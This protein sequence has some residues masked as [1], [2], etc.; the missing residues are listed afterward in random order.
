MKKLLIILLAFISLSAYGQRKQTIR[1]LVVKDSLTIEA[2][3][4]AA[5][6]IAVS[7]DGMGRF[8]WAYFSD[9]QDS[10]NTAIYDTVN[11]N[12]VITQATR[13]TGAALANDT[14]ASIGTDGT[15]TKCAIPCDSL[16]AMQDSLNNTQWVDNGAG[17]T[18]LR[19]IGDNVGIGTDAPIAKLHVDGSFILDTSTIKLSSKT[20][21][22]GFVNG[23]IFNNTNSSTRIGSFDGGL[24]T[25]FRIITTINDDST[26]IEITPT[27]YRFAVTGGG[28][29]GY[30]TGTNGWYISGSF[31]YQDGSQADGYILTS[32]ASGNATWEPKLNNLTNANSGLPSYATVAAA[33]SDGLVSGDAFIL[34]GVTLGASVVDVPCFVP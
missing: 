14:L 27:S 25:D 11:A 13:I 19:T 9:F 6:K 18:V 28:S 15:V 1:E 5:N 23:L 30:N 10:I 7:V 22:G 24:A 2:G 4:P 21:G 32:D 20:I 26:T 16:L 33:I 12:V 3:S 29:F 34:T 8:R 31:N 17:G